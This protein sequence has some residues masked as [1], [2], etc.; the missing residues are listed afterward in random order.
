MSAIS[1]GRPYFFLS[2]PHTPKFVDRDD[3]DPD[4]WAV[5]L[6][7]DLCDHLF[8]ISSLPVHGSIGFMD[9]DL[10]P[11]NEWAVEVANA[12]AAC[13]VFVP[14]YSPRYFSSEHCGREWCAY[15][16]RAVGQPDRRTQRAPGIIPALWVPVRPERLPEPART[17]HYLAGE[18]NGAYASHGLYRLMR[19]SRYKDEYEEAVAA[20][21]RQICEVAESSPVPPGPVAD[22]GS[23]VNAFRLD[24]KPAGEARRP[25]AEVPRRRDEPPLPE[26]WNVPP[27][28]PAFTGRERVLGSLRQQLLAGGQAP[29]LPVVLSGG[30]GVGKTQVAIEYANRHATDYEVVWWV[31]AGQP[32]L[33]NPAFAALAGHLG[34]R[35]SGSIAETAQAVRGALRDGRP[36]SRWLLIFDNA[37]DPGD[38]APFLPG[39]AGQVLITSSDPAWTQV[40][41]PVAVGAFARAESV[42]Y[43][44]RR[45]ASLTEADAELVSGV[46]GD[47]P[48]AVEHASAWLSETAMTAAGYVASIEDEFAA[49][50]SA[51]ALPDYPPSVA[52]V[53]RLSFD[54]LR[55]RSPA[56]ARLL[57]LCAYFAA[58]PISLSLIYGDEAVA[59][60]LPFDPRLRE[61]TV[62]GQ[63]VRDISRYSLAKVD[64]GSNSIQVHRLVQAVIR[65]QMQP[66]QYR[67]DTMHHVHE[68][69]VGA[70]PRK[71]TSTIRRIGR[72]TMRYGRISVR[73]E[74]TGAIPRP[75]V[76][77]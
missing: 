52:V 74:R 21:A 9:R 58:D 31:P 26:A 49:S 13:R 65:E 73:R 30:T 63:L 14:L 4:L 43:L 18:Y 15:T 68:I 56:A 32:D 55:E 71:V 10:R 35:V 33:I 47:M 69:L 75:P 67:E 5:K 6:Y 59:A 76:T 77:C 37:G 12:L 36:R 60:L 23:L 27:R 40:A 8:Q 64:R 3:A 48:L 17:I 22:Y 2:Y 19:M 46:L 42:A 70:R 1:D 34:V 53:L 25:A 45:V 61:R 20:L 72:V 39:G 51:G 41:D 50:G 7:K 16:R 57:E 28:N 66:W 44:R 62:L 54:R 38:L 24:G 29:V 11:G